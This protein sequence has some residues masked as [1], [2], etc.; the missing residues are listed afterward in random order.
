MSPHKYE[1]IV[2]GVFSSPDHGY[3]TIKRDQVVVGLLGIEGDAHSGALRESFRN[4]GT[5]KP[6]DRPISIISIEVINKMNRQFGLKMTEADFNAQL[7]V[8]GLGDLGWIT[9][10]SILTFR[11]GGVVLKITDHAQPCVKLETHNAQVGL[12]KALI[13]LSAPKVDDIVYSRRG[14][15]ASVL[16]PGKLSEGIGI[17]VYQ[18]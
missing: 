12:S 5:L 8:M 1:G 2:T 14:I 16:N 18:A 9:I 17:T 7:G 3:P 6:N 15:L 13:D 10:G 4:K 11:S